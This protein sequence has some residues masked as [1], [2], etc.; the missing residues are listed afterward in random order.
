MSYVSYCHPNAVVYLEVEFHILN[1][2]FIQYLKHT[3]SFYCKSPFFYNILNQ[4]LGMEM[5][6]VPRGLMMRAVIA[7]GQALQ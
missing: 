4:I 6:V 7:Q 5:Q 1:M 3:I 2:S